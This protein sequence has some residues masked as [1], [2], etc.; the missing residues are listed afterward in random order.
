MER[1]Q[2]IVRF[3][4]NAHTHFTQFELVHSFT[5]PGTPM[6]LNFVTGSIDSWDETNPSFAVF[7]LDQETLLPLDYNIYAFDLETANKTPD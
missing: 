6:L 4:A 7:E 1:Y 5:H 2:H 3:G